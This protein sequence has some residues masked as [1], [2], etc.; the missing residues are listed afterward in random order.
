MTTPNFP[1]RLS[2][3]LGLC[4]A[5]IEQP[6]FKFRTTTVAYLSRLADA[7]AAVAFAYYEK[8][9]VE[10]LSTLAQV[11]CWCFTNGIHAFRVNSDLW[12]RATHPL[13]T[14][15]I[16]QLFARADIQSLCQ[17]I[18]ESAI[19]HDVRLSEHP[20]QFLVGNSLRLD[21]VDNTIAELEWRGRLGDA[22]GVEVICLHVGGGLP[23]RESALWRWEPTLARLS[24]SVLQKLALENDDRVFSP[25]QMLPACLA[26]NIP[27]VYDAHHH[28]VLSDSLSIED[29]TEFAIASWGNREPYFHLSSPRAGWDNGDSRPHHDMIEPSDW[30]DAWTALWEAGVRFTVDIE[31]KAKER[32]VLQVRSLFV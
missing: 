32:A 22:I 17:Q 21:V 20:D 26:W 29:A 5:F 1:V 14:P 25:E 4:C 11:I 18:R 27:M 15:W 3:R 6:Q 12:P 2:P 31:A 16:E 10:N 30:P 7:D 8:I 28:R 19:A 23:D 13:V 9:I 24:P